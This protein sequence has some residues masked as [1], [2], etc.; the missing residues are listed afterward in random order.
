MTPPEST[1]EKIVELIQRFPVPDYQRSGIAIKLLELTRYEQTPLGIRPIV[2]EAQ[3]TVGNLVDAIA[4]LSR[5]IKDQSPLPIIVKHRGKV[6]AQFTNP[7]DMNMWMQMS[8]R[9]ADDCEV[10]YAGV[11]VA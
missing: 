5:K 6:V 3:I 7:C 11:N 9:P 8:G 10:T 4:H 2:Q 1:T